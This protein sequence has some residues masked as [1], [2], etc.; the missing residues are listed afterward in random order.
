MMIILRISRQAKLFAYLV[1]FRIYID[2]KY[3]GKISNDDVNEIDI[4][5]GNHSVYI[6]TGSLKSNKLEFTTR[7]NELVDLTCGMSVK[8]L[9]MILLTIVIFIA[10]YILLSTDW[11]IFVKMTIFILPLLYSTKKKQLYIR[12]SDD[13]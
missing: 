2:D 5:D 6:K 12:F 8:N 3:C 1:K 7:D 9:E 11:N 13:M 10:Y 4:E